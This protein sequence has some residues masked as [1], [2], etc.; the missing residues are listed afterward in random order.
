LNKEKK[1]LLCT[2]ETSVEVIIGC[3]QTGKYDKQEEE[4]EE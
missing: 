4:K 3:F 1:F 2:S